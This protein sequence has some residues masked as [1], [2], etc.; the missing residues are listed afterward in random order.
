[1]AAEPKQSS[2]TVTRVSVSDTFFDIACGAVFQTS[3]AQRRCVTLRATV[4]SGLDN[5]LSSS[6]FDRFLWLKRWTTED[7]RGPVP[8]LLQFD[9]AER[10]LIRE[11]Q[12]ML[13]D[14]TLET[15]SVTQTIIIAVLT[16]RPAH[17]TPPR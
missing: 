3:I 13:Q 7:L 16:I 6:R 9:A 5:L 11:T 10:R 4:V 15:V 8:M 2:R 17:S 14:Q 1:M 12:H